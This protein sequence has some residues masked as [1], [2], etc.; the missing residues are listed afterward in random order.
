MKGSRIKTSPDVPW[1]EDAPGEAGS[2]PHQGPNGSKLTMMTIS[3]ILA[4]ED[5]P[6]DILLSNGYIEKGAPFVICGPPGI[7]KSRLALQLA[8]KSALG[9][10]F[11]G[12]ETQADDIKWALLQNENG[13]RRLKADLRVMV[14]DMTTKERESLDRH[15]LIHSIV[16]D[17]DG[18]LDLSDP[19][20]RKRVREVVQDYK[21]GVV[22]GDPLTAFGVGDLNTDRDMLLTARDFGRIV[23]EGDPKRIPGLLHHA[24]TGSIGSQAVTG[25]ERGSFARNSKALYGWTRAQFNVP[26]TTRIITTPWSL[27]PAS[28]ITPAN[29]KNSPSR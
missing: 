7:G 28:A 10:G 15:I 18:H 26:H 1:S 24:R 13:Q 16:T 21:P 29:S 27:L 25:F 9:Q 2:G 20:A 12:W 14:Q 5:D 6:R 11:L 8:I 19:E 22:I 3:E 4:Y 23:R 17:V